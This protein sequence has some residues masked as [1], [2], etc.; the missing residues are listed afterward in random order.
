MKLI[1]E[2]I[3]LYKSGRFPI[4]QIATVYPAEDLDQAI[5]DLQSGQVRLF[6]TKVN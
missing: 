1:P 2:L 3:T 4:D 5:S 6:K